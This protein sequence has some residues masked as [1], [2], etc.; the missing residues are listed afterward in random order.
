MIPT[1]DLNL[2]C[3]YLEDDGSGVTSDQLAI[4]VP[5][6]GL[7]CE[8][9]LR[10]DQERKYTSRYEEGY[11]LPDPEYDA[12]LRVKHPDHLRLGNEH[13]MD[14]FFFHILFKHALCGQV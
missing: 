6:D 10:V 13:V 1:I 5:S 4:D 2:S 7:D 3:L 12:W 14:F 11:N 8:S 9:K